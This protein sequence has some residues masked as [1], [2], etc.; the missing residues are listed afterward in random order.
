MELIDY[1]S[2]QE[3]TPPE[4]L[5]DKPLLAYVQNQANNGVS[6]ELIKFNG[7]QRCSELWYPRFQDGLNFSGIGN[8]GS[9]YKWLPVREIPSV[10][11]PKADPEPYY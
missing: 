7:K 11:L 6:L 2:Y 5:F 3:G 1:T 10:E 4:I 9:V 8:W